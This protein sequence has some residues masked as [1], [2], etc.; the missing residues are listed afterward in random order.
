MAAAE[1]R[2]A[3]SAH[4]RREY[5]IKC[6][7]FLHCIIVIVTNM[8]LLFEKTTNSSYWIISQLKETNDPSQTHEQLLTCELKMPKKSPFTAVTGQQL[9]QSV[10]RSV[11]SAAAENAFVRTTSVTDAAWH[12]VILMTS[13]M[14][15]Q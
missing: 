1:W 9:L 11:K 2:A 14:K 5:D 12:G 6:A 8:Y 7:Y 13:L 4:I 15:C 3:W 10:E